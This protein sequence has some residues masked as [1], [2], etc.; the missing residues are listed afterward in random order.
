MAK[1]D[2]RKGTAGQLVN[3]LRDSYLDR[4][5][6]PV[7]A[8]A[9]LLLFIVIYE[10]GTMLI[11]PEALNQ[12]HEA[13]SRS[14]LRV[15]SFVWLQN[16][17]EY[18]GFSQRFVWV[19]PP[20]AVVLILLGL[21]ISSKTAWK[22]YLSDFIPMTVECILLAI[23]LIVLCLAINRSVSPHSAV[24]AMQTSTA[25]ETASS[26]FWVNIVTGIGAG[27][28]E[29]L[30]F[31]LVLICIL[32]ILFQDLLKLDRTLSVVLSILISA[33]LFSLHHHF[34]FLNGS[35]HSGEAFSFMKFTFRLLAGV[36]FAVLFAVR[37]FG[38]AAGTHAFYDII[39][40][41]LNA[42]VY[43]N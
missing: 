5:S 31:R 26:G 1:N 40:A 10:I 14:Q 2:K 23:P 37:G 22:V 35:L 29:E 39:A 30:V 25:A 33:V 11:S 17:L 41:I 19:A 24:V 15:V 36:Y 9:Y 3:Y 27:I 43:N 28:Y 16:T 8:L 42:I 20:L 6:R 7:Y 18:I 34:F 38:I 32:M 12:A 21:Q 13:Q 4:T